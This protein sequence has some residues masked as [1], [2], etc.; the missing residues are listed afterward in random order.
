MC[1]AVFGTHVVCASA[2]VW[3]LPG[4][5]LSSQHRRRS[6][7]FR[8][9][10]QRTN[11]QKNKQTNKQIFRSTCGV[12][13]TQELSCSKLTIPMS[14]HKHI[15]PCSRTVGI[16]KKIWIETYFKPVT[17]DSVEVFRHFA[18]WRHGTRL[19]TFFIAPKNCIFWGTSFETIKNL[20]TLV[21]EKLQG[22][23][24]TPLYHCC[25]LSS[26][27]AGRS[28]FSNLFRFDSSVCWLPSNK[29]SF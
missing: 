19:T 27:F 23:H 6:I 29:Y 21:P 22:F 11:K 5:L 1:T 20:A 14:P 4:G 16:S 18:F 2:R 10:F 3:S 12:L 15:S 25:T 8:V 26:S 24:G 13:E 7:V 17:V 9:L 28:I